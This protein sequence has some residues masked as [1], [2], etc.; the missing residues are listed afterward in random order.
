MNFLEFFVLFFKENALLEFYNVL[1]VIF[2]T[3]NVELNIFCYIFKIQY[4]SY[5]SL[6]Y[7]LRLMPIRCRIR[8][9]SLSHYLATFLF[10]FGPI[11]TFYI[12]F[13]DFM[14]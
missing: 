7:S 4:S 13:V 11:V 3:D 1:I 10:S 8:D 9:R 6:N 5:V 14:D 2:Q 12:I